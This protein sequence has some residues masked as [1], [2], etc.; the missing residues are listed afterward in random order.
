MNRFVADPHWGGLIV[1]YFF[2]GGIAGGAYV[3]AALADL[4][5][6]D[7]D[8]DAVRVAY[9]LAFPLACICGLL[10]IVDLN[11]PERFWHMLIKSNTGWPVFKWWSPMS[12]G[13]WALT[14]FGAFS[15]ASFL[16]VLAQDGRLGLGRFAP[17]ARRLRTGWT[18]RLFALGGAIAA[19]FLAS[20]TGVLLTAT[21]QP[22]WSDTTWI[23]PLFLASAASSGVAALT[24][25]NRLRRRPVPEAVAERLEWL[26]GWAM[27]LELILLAA[28]ALSL[29]TLA[30]PAFGRWP[31][32]LIPGFVVPLGL[33]LPLALRRWAGARVGLAS[34]LLVL[35][36]GL[37]LR[38]AL[39]GTPPALL[40][41]LR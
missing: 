12:A 29:G 25:A 27:V 6:D 40:V 36:G 28:M 15:F 35:S 39:V 41:S 11:R 30:K 4:L 18:G 19:F 20:Y 21:N 23:G 26:D 17:L 14:A 32:L 13:S 3:T 37:A 22:V 34:A 9:Y 24:L 10:L 1:A 5:G 2:L 8:R 33:L 16:G 31:G 38:A 7:D